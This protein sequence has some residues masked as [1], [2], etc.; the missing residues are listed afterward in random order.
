MSK[1]TFNSSVRSRGG[2]REDDG[3]TPAGM[4]MSVQC[5]AQPS[6]SNLAV[7]VGTDPTDGEDLV[8]PKGAIIISFTMLDNATGTTPTFDIGTS[9]DPD[10]IFNELDADAAD[11]T[12]IYPTG[13]L[14]LNGA[15]GLAA[16]TAVTAT[17]GSGGT[18]TSN[19]VGAMTYFI[20]DNGISGTL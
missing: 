10:G 3:V 16:D 19:M 12:V 15:N 14:V 1:T 9:D 13:A 8:L 7:K 20:K 17:N 18:P 6:A 11:G 4:L 5:S 2:R